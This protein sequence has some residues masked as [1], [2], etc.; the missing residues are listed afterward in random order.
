MAA[1]ACLIAGCAT[2]PVKQTERLLTQSGFKA[3]KATTPEQLQLV[4][5]LPAEKVSPVKRKGQVYYVYPDQGRNF[6]YVG[7]KEQ[8]Q[9]YRRA[10]QDQYL[11]ADGKLLREAHESGVFAQD[12]LEMSGA[13]PAFEPIWWGW[14]E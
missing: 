9:L 14:P 5:T 8:L 11:A 1:L 2:S 7:N 13:A 10:V 4:K 6:L 3:L 12:S